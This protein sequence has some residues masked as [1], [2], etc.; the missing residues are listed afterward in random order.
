M[1]RT[2]PSWMTVL[3]FAMLMLCARAAFAQGDDRYGFNPMPPIVMPASPEQQRLMPPEQ[4]QRFTPPP[5]PPRLTTP[6]LRQA[7]KNMPPPV[8]PPPSAPDAAAAPEPVPYGYVPL[9]PQ[10]AENPGGVA[11]QTAADPQMPD[12]A[13][14]LAGW[15]LLGSGD[16]LRVSVLGEDDLSGEY[17]IDGSGMVQLPLIGTLRAAGLTAPVLETGIAG[18]LA[19]GYLKNPRIKVEIVTYRPFSIIGAV[20]RPGQYP[21]LD[22]MSALSAVAYGGGFTEQARESVVY[23]RHEGSMVEEELP[24][25]Q[26]TRIWPGDVVR[27]KNTVFW[28]VMNIFAPLAAPAALAAAVIQ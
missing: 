21:Y 20:N 24:A 27:V 2:L 23:V 8:R 7:Q 1:R 9:P 25:S 3:A 19:R 16:R 12:A 4:P 11:A 10:S 18:A 17:Q 26:M 15:Y 14:S 13:N 28:D 6:P 22:N 5:A